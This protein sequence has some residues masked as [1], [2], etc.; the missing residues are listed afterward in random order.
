MEKKHGMNRTAKE[1]KIVSTGSLMLDRAIGVGGTALG[2]MIE[3][4]GP[5]SCGKS[6]IVLHQLAEYQKAFPD[7]YVAI[8]DFEHCFDKNYASNPNIGL[9]VDKVLIYQ[10][11]NQE[12]GFDMLISLV[13][14]KIISCAALDSQTA[15]IPLKIVE[16]DMSDVT[17]GLQAR[18][19]SKFCGKIKG[20]L[21]NHGVT[22]F[23]ISQTRANIGGMGSGDVPTGGNSWKFYCDLRLKV[24][25]SA[26]KANEL[27]KTTV[28][29]IKN[30][31]EKPFGQAVINIVWGEGFDKLGELVDLAVE[32]DFIKL[33]GAGWYTVGES[34]IQGL[35]NLKEF[36]NDNPE[37]LEELKGKVLE[38]LSPKQE[39]IKEKSEEISQ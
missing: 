32:F 18:N 14:N 34:K 12:S 25:K 6:T 38:K 33:G 7:R 1:L 16:G 27:N 17:M 30:K 37:F 26:D 8:F 19:N 36:L 24:W 11:D 39:E 22:L 21:D 23:V 35:N 15:A 3:I 28:D 2:K 9:N 5:E 13:E 4:Y 10:P 20:L 31:L 29:V